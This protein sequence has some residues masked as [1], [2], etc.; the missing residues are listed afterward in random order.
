MLAHVAGIAKAT[1]ERIDDEHV[2]PRRAWHAM[3]E[4]MR[5]H[6]DQVAALARASELVSEPAR[7]VVDGTTA[8]FGL[9][10][11]PQGTILLTVALA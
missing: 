10:V 11:P 7:H 1:P 2:N 3:G 9:I 5:P 8:T 6:P 4:P